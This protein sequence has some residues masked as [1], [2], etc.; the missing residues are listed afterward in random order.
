M[1][2]EKLE[3]R[4]RVLEDMEE[5][6][7]L[8]REYIYFLANRQWNELVDCFTENALYDISYHGPRTGKK[9][10]EYMVKNEFE[11]LV[12]PTHGHF[13]TQPVISVEGD[14]ANGYWI[15]YIFIPERDVS[16]GQ[17]RHDCEYVREDGKW[18]ISSMIFRRW[19][20]QTE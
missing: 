13:S 19:P 6:R 18:K 2:L 1:T 20:E 7:Q 3:K 16:W 12:K 5:I 10:M 9:E 8:H 15:L 14:R 4:I 11:E 17:G